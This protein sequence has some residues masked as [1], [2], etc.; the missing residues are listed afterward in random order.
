MTLIVWPA[1]DLL[2]KDD[3]RAALRDEPMQRWPEVPLVIKPCAFACLGERLARTAS[4]P[5]GAVVRPSGLPES[6]GPKSDAGEEVAAVVGLEVVGAD[7]L[8]APGV[9][10]SV[11]KKSSCDEPVEPVCFRLI[12]LVVVRTCHTKPLNS[13]LSHRP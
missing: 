6:K 12:D 10:V 11:R 4:G 3:W 5:D 7:V 9:D 8:D 13:H 1:R 2:S